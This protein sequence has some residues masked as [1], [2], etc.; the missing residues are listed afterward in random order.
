MQRLGNETVQIC[1]AWHLSNLQGPNAL[2]VTKG[3]C[4]EVVNS[5]KSSRHRQDSAQTI[6]VVNPYGS[7]IVDT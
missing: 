3:S 6:A 5:A 1:L 7:G 2:P 4:T